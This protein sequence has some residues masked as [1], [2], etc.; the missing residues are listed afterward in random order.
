MHT[1]EPTT[2]ATATEKNQYAILSKNPLS[3]CHSQKVPVNDT[4]VFMVREMFGSFF[5]HIQNNRIRHAY[6]ELRSN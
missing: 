6:R 4:F 3:I 2:T 1:K 5:R